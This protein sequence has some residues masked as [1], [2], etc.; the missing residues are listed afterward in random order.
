MSD[1]DETPGL[2]E[3][4]YLDDAP[5]ESWAWEYLRRNP[6]YRKAWEASAEPGKA[7]S[8][9]GVIPPKES[10]RAKAFGLLFF[11]QPKP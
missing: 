3:Y 4:D 10:E 7:T 5:A 6:A 8:S 11:R 2:K 9:S 1:R